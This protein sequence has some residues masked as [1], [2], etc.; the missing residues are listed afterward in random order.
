MDRRHRDRHVRVAVDQAQSR[1][2]AGAHAGREQPAAIR[3]QNGLFI[4][5]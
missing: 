2:L 4:G 3:G 5:R 1:P